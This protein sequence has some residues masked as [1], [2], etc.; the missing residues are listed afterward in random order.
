LARQ[1]P[2]DVSYE[3]KNR[4]TLSNIREVGRGG[5]GS[6]LSRRRYEAQTQGRHQIHAIEEHDDE[7]FIVMEYIEGQELREIIAGNFTKPQ[8]FSKVI[9]YVTQ[10]AEGLPVDKIS[11]IALEINP[12][13]FR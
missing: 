1:L 6:R 3:W 9:D 12:D 7:M 10:I 5:H 13:M 11:E 8:R 4:F 2:G